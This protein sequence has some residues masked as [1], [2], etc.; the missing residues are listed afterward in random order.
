MIGKNFQLFD[1]LPAISNCICHSSFFPGAFLFFC[2]FVKLFLLCSS[3]FRREEDISISR[4]GEDA[5]EAVLGV[6]LPIN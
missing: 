4:E 1:L 5:V 2:A 3:G 6:V